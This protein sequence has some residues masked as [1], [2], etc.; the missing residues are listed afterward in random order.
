MMERKNPLQQTGNFNIQA[1]KRPKDLRDL[2]ETHVSFSGSP[3]KHPHDPEKVV[4]VADPY[5][6]HTSLYEFNTKDI[7]YVEKLPNLV[8]LEGETITMTRVWVRK[9]SIGI[10]C[11]PFLAEDTR[12]GT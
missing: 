1:Y 7:S 9:G 8:N 12:M 4:L 5:S 10:R 11:T 3:R 2:W 6:S